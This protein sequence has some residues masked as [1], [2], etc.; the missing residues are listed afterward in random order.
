MN[1]PRVEVNLASITLDWP[2]GLMFFRWLHH[3]LRPSKTSLLS[4]FLSRHLPRMSCEHLSQ[5]DAFNGTTG[6]CE[7]LGC[8]ALRSIAVSDPW[9]RKP[10]CVGAAGFFEPA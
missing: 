3:R 9:T 7:R 2:Y 10:R 6:N 8:F 4:P 1:W 5:E